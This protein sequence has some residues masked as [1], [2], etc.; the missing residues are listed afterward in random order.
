VLYQVAQGCQY[1]TARTWARSG[2]MNFVVLNLSEILAKINS[3]KLAVP[4]FSQILTFVI[5]LKLPLENIF[6]LPDFGTNSMHNV[7][8]QADTGLLHPNRPRPP[9]IHDF[10]EV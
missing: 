10:V 9:Y 8:P 4:V 5:S 6:V 1:N 7:S 3:D 2:N